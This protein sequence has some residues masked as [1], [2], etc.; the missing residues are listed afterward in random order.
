MTAKPTDLDR[1]EALPAQIILGAIF[2]FMG[3][4]T[5]R[6]ETITLSSNHEPHELLAAF[7]EWSDKRGLDPDEKA[8]ISE[9]QSCVSHGTFVRVLEFATAMEKKLDYAKNRAKGDRKTWLEFDHLTIF[10][11]LYQEVR[12]LGYSLGYDIGPFVQVPVPQIGNPREESID[13]ANISMM[14]F[15]RENQLEILELLRSFSQQGALGDS[16]QTNA[17]GLDSS[18]SESRESEGGVS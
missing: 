13:I 1:V 12:E 15:D 10:R 8:L 6:P 17:S 2:D 4:I 5:C 11:L 7:R 9:W 14:I 18:P 3:Y 16:I